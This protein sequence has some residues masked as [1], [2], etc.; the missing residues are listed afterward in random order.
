MSVVIAYDQEFGLFTLA[1]LS[2]PADRP[3]ECFQ[4]G[5]LRNVLSVSGSAEDMSIRVVAE[6][7]GPASPALLALGASGVEVMQATA[8][9]SRSL[10]RRAGALDIEPGDTVYVDAGDEGDLYPIA[11]VLSKG[12]SAA[13]MTGDTPSGPPIGRHSRHLHVVAA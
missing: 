11:V 10:G 4:S 13:E 8:A 5:V 3:P 1:T 9:M 7:I 12:G 2:D 6:S